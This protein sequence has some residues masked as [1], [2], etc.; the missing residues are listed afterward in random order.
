MPADV[1]AADYL[2]P[3]TAEVALHCVVGEIVGDLA[4]APKEVGP[5]GEA[6]RG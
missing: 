2:Q 4:D 6:A 5:I 3:S 1:R